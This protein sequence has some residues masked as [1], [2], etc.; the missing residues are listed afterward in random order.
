MAARFAEGDLFH[1]L[2][3]REHV[4]LVDN[5]ALVLGRDAADRL[6]EMCATH[7][8]RSSSIGNSRA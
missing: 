8:L 1:E 7:C 6:E 5:L 2:V 3:D 4:L